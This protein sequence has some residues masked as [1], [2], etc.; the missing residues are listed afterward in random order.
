MRRIAL[1]VQ[2]ALLVPMA[3][4]SA[5]LTLRDGTVIYG[6]FVGGSSGKI[7]FQDSRGARRTFTVP[8]IR[9]IDFRTSEGSADRYFPGDPLPGA[10]TPRQPAF[11]STP[12]GRDETQYGETW[13]T[14]FPG[15][16]L[17]VRVI[18]A[19]DAREAAE[20]RTYPATIAQDVLDGSGK[21]VIGRGSEAALVV[22]Q[23]D[24][25]GDF[26]S[27]ALVLDLDSV[28]VHGR[29]YLVDTAAVRTDNQ[30]GIGANRRT[31]EMVG[32]GAALGTLVGAL[33]GGGK[34]AAIG[35]IAGAAA[36]GGVQVLTRGKE[37]KVPAETVLNFRLEQP[38]QLRAAR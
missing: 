16:V 5:R 28:R 19:I 35:A 6:E 25:G 31:A 26:G 9:E 24:E 3:L 21:L 13:T 11:D 23:I 14:L 34:G 27:G 22:R 7:V 30:R 15:T 4:S 32:G 12:P 2:I 10:R 38:M 1:L 37:I 8:Q 36:G 17:S 33:A 18:E 20:G 29:R